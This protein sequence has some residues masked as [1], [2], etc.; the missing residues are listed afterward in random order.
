LSLITSA[1]IGN[2]LYC[3]RQY[4]RAIEQFQKIIQ[5]D[6]NSALA[7][8]RL[9]MNYLEKGMYEEAIAEHKKAIALDESPRRI[10]W[11]GHSYAA[12][13]K[14]AEALKILDDLKERAKQRPV[15]PYEFALIYLGLGDKD[16]AFVWLE[17]TIEERPDVLC[18][19]NV[20]LRLDRF[21]S[22]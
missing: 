16:Q 19:I 1:E 10:A 18:D 17:K 7:H 20:G 13:G 21:R 6:P 4:D 9:G 14:K 12:A 15:S 5:M 8:T 11:L 22:H 3:S 2:M